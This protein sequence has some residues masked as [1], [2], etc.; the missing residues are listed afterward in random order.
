MRIDTPTLKCD[1]C[2]YTTTD[3]SEMVTFITLTHSHV[4]G[5]KTWDL[6]PMCR[7]EFEVFTRGG[8]F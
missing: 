8:E 1:R 7:D 4:S 5:E 2:G 6:C 3:L